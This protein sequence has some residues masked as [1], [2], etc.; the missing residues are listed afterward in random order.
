[1]TLL[2]VVLTAS[3]AFADPAGD[4]STTTTLSLPV[5]ESTTTTVTVPNVEPPVGVTTTTLPP[6]PTPEEL[7]RREEEARLRQEE[8]QRR[9]ARLQE[10]NREVSAKQLEVFRISLELDIMDE[11]LGAKVEDYNL[12]VLD[13][14]RAREEALRMQRELALTED[15]LAAMHETLQDRVVAAYKSDL[16]ALEVLLDTTDMIDFVKR[17]SLILA[18]ARSDQA[19]LDEVVALRSRASRLLDKLSV[20]IYRVTTASERLEKEKKIIED[21]VSERRTYI[22]RLT[23]EIR[24]LVDEQR[25]VGSNVVPSGFD[26]GAF[27]AGDGNEIVK[28]ALKYLGV[29]YVWGGATPAGFDCSGLVQYVFMQQGIYV[30]HYSRYQALMGVEVPLEAILPG[31]LVFFGSPVYHVGIAMGNDLFVHAPRTGDVVKISRLSDRHDL[32]HI[33]RLAFYGPPESG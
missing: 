4:D 5:E 7:A 15:E 17:V 29:P 16:S 2:L 24:A 14:E 22:D 1:V 31:D 20:Q 11:E 30:P 19:R 8:V 6:G 18:I 28:S 27:L 26:V 13:L 33:R 25:Q 32:S 12:A 3:V 10:L 23:A 9:L 21:K